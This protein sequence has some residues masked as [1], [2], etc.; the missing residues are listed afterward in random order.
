MPSYCS[1]K[2]VFSCGFRLGKSLI[3]L[4][5]FRITILPVRHLRCARGHGLRLLAG[6][7]FSEMQRALEVSIFLKARVAHA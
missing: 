7:R 4:P 1:H 6:R 2:L 3:R 5:Q